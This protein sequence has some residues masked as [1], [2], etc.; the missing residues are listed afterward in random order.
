MTLDEQ[1]TTYRMRLFAAIQHA[2]AAD[3]GGKSYEG[4]IQI[5]FPG[6]YCQKVPDMWEIT[7]DCYILGPARHYSY[8]GNDL[9]ECFAKANADLDQW[10]THYN[11]VTPESPIP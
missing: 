9:D 1:I 3:G 7:V 2:L 5:H 8:V 10:I 6:Y 11:A 4:Q